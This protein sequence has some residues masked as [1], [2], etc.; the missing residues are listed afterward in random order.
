[1]IPARLAARSALAVVIV[2][3]GTAGCG[4]ATPGRPGTAAGCAA[5]AVAAVGRHRTLA[6]LPVP[7][8]GLGAGGLDQAVKIAVAELSTA[9]DKAVRR[10]QAGL[11]RQRLRYLIAAADR[12]GAAAARRSARRSAPARQGPSGPEIPQIPVGQAA[13]AAWLLAA[14]SG[15]VL[16]RGWLVHA[17]SRSS[18]LRPR[19]ADWVVL[20]H[21]GLAL[22]GLAAWAGYL[23]TAW[24][25]L[26]W[27]AAGVLLPVAGL[28]MSVLLLSI[29]DSGRARPASARPGSARPAS[30][31][32]ASARPA[33]ARP[34]RAPVVAITTHG[35]LA[36]L[37]MLL[38]L[39]GAVAAI[40]TG[41]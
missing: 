3:A 18:G 33:S 17:R 22:A 29:S 12:A 5:S 30:A 2:A 14:A 28:G 35:A 40:T 41:R 6:R 16:F 23:V 10:H 27:A 21:A 11:A 20:A 26:A 39:L 7:C 1:V 4:V 36:T 32:P 13:L 15:G 37:V 19:G 9:P 8:R 25:P 38:A 34:G 31:R 24:I